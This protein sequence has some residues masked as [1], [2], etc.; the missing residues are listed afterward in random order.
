[1]ITKK[2]V[3]KFPQRLIEQP[4]IYKLAKDFALEF[5]ILKANIIPEREAFLVLELKGTSDNYKK[6]MKYLE[7]LGI[8]A[9]PLSK[10]VVRDE[11]KCTHCGA[12]VTVCSVNAF[13]VDK[14]TKKIAFNEKECIACEQCIT[15]CPLH[16][17]EVHF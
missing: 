5:N 16:A 15:A 14:K 9:Q 2:I 10:D 17:M 1:M 6:G 13:K 7:G 8:S 12:C 4:V 11:K 3:L